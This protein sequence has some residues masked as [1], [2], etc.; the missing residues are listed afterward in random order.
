MQIG[1]DANCW[2][3]RRGYGRFARELLHALLHGDQHNTYCL[4]LD[5]GTKQQAADIPDAVKQ[6]IVPTS[7]AAVEAASAS[8]HRSLHDLWVMGEAVRRHR[9]PLDMFYFPSVYT[10]YPLRIRKPIAVSIHDTIPERYPQLV[11]SGRMQRLMWTLKVRWAVRQATA[12]LTVSETSRRAI[13]STFGVPAERVHVVAD[14]PSAIF[15]P[16]ADAARVRPVLARYGIAPQE[17]YILYVGGIS[18]HKNLSTL[19]EA[20]AMLV[21][22]LSG[23]DPPRLV[24]VGDCQRDV[25]LS[26]FAELQRKAEGPEL[27]GRVIFTGFVPDDELVCLYSAAELLVMPAFD[28]GFGLPA[29]EAMACGTP[30]VA[31]HAG[32]LPEVVGDAGVFFDPRSPTEL[33]T[34]LEGLLRDDVRRAAMRARGLNRASDFSWKRSAAAALAAF[35][36]MMTQ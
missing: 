10:F 1:V 36:G 26:S 8:G 19:L 16:V 3:N 29:V 35:E 2:A 17:C 27:A 23:S 31:S 21:A 34:C 13:A 12:I 7:Q 32:A 33:K 22:S 11:F 20:Y 5:A 6:V 30:V 28:E 9:P 4:F 25:F 15:R 24:L 14:A 18:P